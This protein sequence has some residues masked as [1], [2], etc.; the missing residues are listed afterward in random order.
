MFRES[1]FLFTL[2]WVVH[3][4]DPLEGAR[5]ASLKSLGLRTGD[6]LYLLH[7]TPRC[8]SSRNGEVTQQVIQTRDLEG[9][10]LMSSHKLCTDIQGGSLEEKKL[11]MDLGDDDELMGPHASLQTDCSN[12]SNVSSLQLPG[13]FT[14]VL[15][16]GANRRYSK[17]QYGI[18][19]LLTH[20]VMLET[21]FKLSEENSLV[22]QAGKIDPLLIPQECSITPGITRFNYVILDKNRG[23]INEKES[24]TELVEP[25]RWC[26]EDKQELRCNSATIICSR[27]G[28]NGMIITGGTDLGAKVD[29][30]SIIL[31]ISSYFNSLTSCTNKRE[32]AKLIH[33]LSDDYHG[34][35]NAVSWDLNVKKIRELWNLIKDKIAL[36]ILNQIY[37]SHG[38]EAPCS[39]L[40]LPIDIKTRILSLLE[41]FDLLALGQV[42]SELRHQS[43][44]DK[45]WKP[46]FHAEFSSPLEWVVDRIKYH[47][48]KW[49]FS[50]SWRER[51]LQRKEQE[52]SMRRRRRFA[53]AVPQFS[54]APFYPTRPSRNFPGIG[55][56]Y[57]RLPFLGGT[58]N[59]GG[60][61]FGSS[62]RG[63][64][65]SLGAGQ[66]TSRFHGPPHL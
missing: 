10:C 4:Q 9:D 18:L 42:C 16:F 32:S 23:L 56:E 59:I 11:G 47:G 20:A 25:Q 15:H 19:T 3:T 40:T 54:P 55:G 28:Q 17:S 52:E 46:L 31:D 37:L 36:P 13:Y 65:G 44:D 24:V 50:I 64:R 39:F 62:F 29:L 53:P 26:P 66:D 33:D 49:A 12:D 7:P 35:I 41:P 22:R 45:L 5:C 43:S 8:N 60:Y 1:L 6:L 38:I 14:Q 34:N 63:M 57:D 27:I 58:G 21:G 2:V 51:S 30:P 61:A 48:Y